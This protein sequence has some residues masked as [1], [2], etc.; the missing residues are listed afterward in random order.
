MITDWIQSNMMHNIVKY[1]VVKVLAPS[2]LQHVRTRVV[3]CFIAWSYQALESA[4]SWSDSQMDGD[5][6]THK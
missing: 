5:H 3:T 6:D 4:L 2:R 1:L